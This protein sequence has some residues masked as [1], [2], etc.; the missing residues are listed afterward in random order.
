DQ[1]RVLGNLYRIVTSEGHVKWVCF[2]H[3]RAT[4]RATAIKRLQ[5]TVDVNQ[6]IYIEETG[7]IEIAITSKTLA[8]EFYGAMVKA[9]W[10]QELDIMLKWDATMEDLQEFANAVT[11]A[12]VVSLTVDGSFFKRPALDV[13]NRTRRFNPIMKL[14]SNSRIQSFRIKGFEDFFSRVS[15]SSLAPAPKLR[16][17]SLQSE[18]PLQDKARSL[19]NLLEL[20]S[21]LKALDVKLHQS[22]LITKIVSDIFSKLPQ[23]QLLKIDRGTNTFTSSL[24]KDMKQAVIL[25]VDHL[26]HLTSDDIEF[27]QEGCSKLAVNCTS[28]DEDENRLL[29][30]PHTSEYL[31]RIAHKATRS[32]VIATSEWKLQELAGLITSEFSEELVSSSIDCQRLS[33]TVRFSQSRSQNMTMTIERLDSLNPDDLSYI[34]QGHLIRLVMKRIPVKGDKDRLTNI[35]RHNQTLSCLR[36]RYGK[37]DDPDPTLEMELLDLMTAIPSNTSSELRS[38]SVDCQRLSLITGFSQGRIQNMTMTIER[39]DSL[40]PGDLTYIQQGHL[41]QLIVK[42]TP[43]KADKDRLTDVLR[44]NQT[45]SHLEF[46]YGERNGPFTSNA[47]EM[48]LPDLVSVVTSAPCTLESLQIDYEE[49]KMT[50]SVLHGKAQDIFVTIKQLGGLQVDDLSFIH[51]GCLSRLEIRDTPREKDRDHLAQILQHNPGL[52]HLQIGRNGEHSN[53]INS[54]PHMKLRDLVVLATSNAFLKLESLEISDGNLSFTPDIAQGRFSNVGTTIN[55]VETFSLDGFKFIQEYHLTKLALKH[56]PQKVDESQLTTIL[57]QLP[58]LSHLQVGCRGECSFAIVNLIVA[59]RNIIQE[60]GSCGLRTFELM[61]ESMVPFDILADIIDDTHIHSHL[62]F[63]DGSKEF[64]MR[65]WIRL[66]SFFKETEAVKNFVCRYGR[67][68]VCFGGIMKLPS[69]IFTYLWNHIPGTEATQL[70]RIQAHV[71]D[72]EV[73]HLSAIIRRSPDFKSLDLVAS[74]NNENQFLKVEQLTI[75]YRAT[76]TGLF[77]AGESSDRLSKI[78]LSIPTRSSLPILEKFELGSTGMSFTWNHVQWIV[79]MVSGPPRG[80]SSPSVSQPVLQA[81]VAEHGLTS[82]PELAES[83]KPL[84]KITLQRITLLPEDWSEIMEAIDF[85]ALEYLDLFHSNI[86]EEQFRILVDRMVGAK[87]SN[88]RLRI[89]NIKGTVIVKK[90]S[91]R[92]LKTMV[93]E[94]Q[95]KAP[96]LKVMVTQE[97]QY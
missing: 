87:E 91:T 48:R 45:L 26:N 37:E 13:V 68:I 59:T 97:L 46:R 11:K 32:L 73:D 41:T 29:G 76:L 65:T 62:L 74:L 17:L 51:R 19:D 9:R 22:A 79:A 5:E 72:L 25:T 23:L 96:V 70:E 10:I 24:A 36:F 39:L 21:A 34:Q 69:N 6:G 49:L 82:E 1:G 2:D 20:Y 67:S 4:Y 57:S 90:A 53:A 35:L 55:R 42:R 83:W 81:I 85:S 47:P 28:W 56:T 50:A 43:L 60:R 77:L 38:L 33:L 75:R 93:E 61:A 8:R 40:D 12:N 66:K 88:L 54:D 44:H 7:R 18:L 14:V 63:H 84:R 71:K 3:Y 30:F 92:A 78:V 94:L 95:K 89:L 64:D 27:I 15:K 80:L 52:V 16:E 31:C 86:A 58:T